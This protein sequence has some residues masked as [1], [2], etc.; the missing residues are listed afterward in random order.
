LAAWCSAQ[1]VLHNGTSSPGEERKQAL[2]L[3]DRASIL[4]PDDPLVLTARC[5]VH[6][7]AGNFEHARDLIARALALDPTFAW[8]WE[9]SGWLNAFAGE[10]ETAIQHFHEASRLDWRPPEANRLIGIGCAHFDAGRY[11]AAAFWK[12]KALLQQPG[13]AWINRTLCVSY[14][15]VGERTAA[16]DSLAALRRYSPDLTI[17]QIVASIPF[18]RDFLDRVAEGLDDL[19]LAD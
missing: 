12:R 14:A 5:G 10:P 8:S 17:H 6:T 16:L 19:G 9:R 3:S 7:M 13:T 2:L 15:R 4:D 1:L 18:T 11:E